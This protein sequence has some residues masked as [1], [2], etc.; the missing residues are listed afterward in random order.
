MRFTVDPWD[1]SYGASVETELGQSA[2]EAEVE[3]EVA[4]QAWAPVSP[5]DGTA[6]PDAVL[7]VDG[8]RGDI[9]HLLVL[10][11]AA[12]EEHLTGFLRVG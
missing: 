11:D 2:V 1:P 9:R 12:A 4:R 7:F 8:V 6:P 10:R 5:R 3:V